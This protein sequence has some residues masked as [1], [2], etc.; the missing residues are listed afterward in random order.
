MEDCGTRAIFAR[1]N[2]SL[3]P[4]PGAISRRAGTHMDGYAPFI[5]S[6]SLFLSIILETDSFQSVRF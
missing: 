1:C 4:G 5:G 2:Y 6:W 3:R